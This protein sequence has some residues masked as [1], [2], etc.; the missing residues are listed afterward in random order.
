[1]LLDAIIIVLQESLEAGILIS[2]LLAI[3]NR[4]RHPLSWFYWGL[5][6]GLGGSVLYAI[7][8]RHISE[9]FDYVGQEVLN[10]SIQYAIY[11]C[12]LI[13]LWHL[14][15]GR[16]RK[17]HSL[18]TTM[19]L[20]IVFAMVREGSEIIVFYSGIIFSNGQLTTGLTSA[21]IGLT[22][23]CSAGALCYYAVMAIAQNR[24][25]GVQ[26]LLL[27]VIAAGMV[28]QA[29]QLL[30]QADWLPQGG[31]LWDTSQILPENSIP[32][33][34][35]YAIVGYEATPT[36]VEVIFYCTALLSTL[37]LFFKS[38]HSLK[39]ATPQEPQ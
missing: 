10:A 22:L 21:F 9:W 32:G 27:S 31:P 13:L 35:A 14:S 18:L 23:G 36:G 19:S 20:I 7:N 12:I 34:L 17:S 15:T 5:A 38:R 8:L 30:I 25:I 26:F 39:R 11:V 16:W 2:L 1:M 3:G 24:A 37:L 4:W 6:G 28:G 29:T 33:Q